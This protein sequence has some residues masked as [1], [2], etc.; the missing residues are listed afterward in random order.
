MPAFCAAGRAHGHRRRSGCEAAEGAAADHRAAHR[1]LSGAAGQFRKHE[2]RRA[3]VRDRAAVGGTGARDSQSAGQH[4]RRGRDPAAE[5]GCR[6]K[7]TECVAIIDKECERLNRLLTNFL[8]FAR[9]RTPHYQSVDAGSDPEFRDG[10]GA[11]RA[12]AASR[13]CCEKKWRPTCP[14]CSAI[15]SNSRQVLLNLVINAVQA[16]DEQGR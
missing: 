4:R 11:A 12:R 1:S 16:T 9:P 10:S 14:G 5:S 3:A 7:R 6:E 15:R 8:Q 13:S 2:A